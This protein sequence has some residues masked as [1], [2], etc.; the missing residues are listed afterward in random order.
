MI[1][2]TSHSHNRLV[3]LS[4]YCK[5]LAKLFFSVFCLF[6]YKFLNNY[7]KRQFLLIL[8]ETLQQYLGVFLPYK[9]GSLCQ[10]LQLTFD[11]RIN[12]LWCLRHKKNNTEKAKVRNNNRLRMYA[13]YFLHFNCPSHY[14]QA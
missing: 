3:F 1:T 8:P 4:R 11:Q 2:F 6:W 12:N 13:R 14:S 7:Q 9:F 5:M 10:T